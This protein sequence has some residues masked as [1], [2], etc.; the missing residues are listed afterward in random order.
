MWSLWILSCKFTAG[1]DPK[2]LQHQYFQEQM[3]KNGHKDMCV[4]MAATQRIKWQGFQGDSA[5]YR[6]LFLFIYFS[7]KSLSSWFGARGETISKKHR[8]KSQP[9]QK[10]LFMK[11]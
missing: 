5:R 6:D 4:F 7:P 11:E 3:V 2:R 10:K 8:A 9:Q 1:S